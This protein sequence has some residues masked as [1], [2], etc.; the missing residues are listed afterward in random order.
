MPRRNDGRKTMNMPVITCVVFL[1]AAVS[2]SRAAVE[3]ETP[4]AESAGTRPSAASLQK[5][6]EKLRGIQKPKLGPTTEWTD[7]EERQREGAELLSNSERRVDDS[8]R[9]GIPLFRDEESASKWARQQLESNWKRQQ[10]ESETRRR[11]WEDQRQQMMLWRGVGTGVAA[12]V[13][14][15]VVQRYRN[16][17]KAAQSQADQLKARVCELEEKLK[18]GP[19]P[20]SGRGPGQ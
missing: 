16:R 8:R 11:E 5:D 2:T 4:R 19:S 9:R 15:I 13:V 12:V 18:E 1:L 6:V 17:A 20:P 7:F 10:Q 3:N 14:G